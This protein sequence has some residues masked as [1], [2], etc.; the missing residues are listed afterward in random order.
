MLPFLKINRLMESIS[1]FDTCRI[2]LSFKHLLFAN[3]T[4][5]EF[6]NTEKVCGGFSQRQNT[7]Q[8]PAAHSFWGRGLKP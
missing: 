8:S 5:Q 1:K 6:F 2:K 7:K 3:T 4:L